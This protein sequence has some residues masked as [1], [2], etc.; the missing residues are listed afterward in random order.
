MQHLTYKFLQFLRTMRSHE[1]DGDFDIK[2]L[3]RGYGYLMM[4]MEE[5][6][7]KSHL[8][9]SIFE[10]KCKEANAIA[11]EVK[12][13]SVKMSDRQKYP[14]FILAFGCRNKFVSNL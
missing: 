4:D 12:W 14:V 6:I 11:P 7:N 9:S 10:D 3:D 2:T 5:I 8:K 13:A 1:K